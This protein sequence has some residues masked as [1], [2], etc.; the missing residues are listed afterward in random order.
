MSTQPQSGPEPGHE[1]HPVPRDPP[2]QQAG[3]GADAWDGTPEPPPREETAEGT[4]GPD[5]G[6]RTGEDIG[7][8]E[9]PEP[10]EPSA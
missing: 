3:P 7:T 5:G 10:D 4:A 6:T 1:E 9:Q 2:D 8:D